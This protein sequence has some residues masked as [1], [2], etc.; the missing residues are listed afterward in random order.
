MP[1]DVESFHD[2]DTNLYQWRV[3]YANQLVKE[4]WETQVKHE[5]SFR[6]VTL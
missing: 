6:N 1:V 3:N 4:T 2:P 5:G